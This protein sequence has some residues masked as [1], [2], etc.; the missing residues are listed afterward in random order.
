MG[1][2]IHRLLREWLQTQPFVACGFTWFLWEN[3]RIKPPSASDF[4]EM[5]MLVQGIKIRALWRCVRNDASPSTGINRE[6]RGSTC[7]AVHACP[8]TLGGVLKSE[9]HHVWPCFTG[10][11][12]WREVGVHT[13]LLGRF[14]TPLRALCDLAVHSLLFLVAADANIIV[15]WPRASGICVTSG[16]ILC[17][18]HLI[19]QVTTGNRW[20]SSGHCDLSRRRQLEVKRG[21]LISLRRTCA[22]NNIT[23]AVRMV[24]PWVR[25]RKLR[26]CGHFVGH[27]LTCV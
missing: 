5:C 13:L 22:T 25:L 24:M 6:Q 10:A 21:L 2:V 7:G 3:F 20:N 4:E 8:L 9:R 12:E 1:F 15:S 26:R 11:A 14:A 16:C 19:Q 27:T 17:L 23:F 18:C